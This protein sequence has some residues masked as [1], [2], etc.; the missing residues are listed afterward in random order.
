[1]RPRTRSA[2]WE[3]DTPKERA[4]PGP[5]LGQAL[6]DHWGLGR[7]FEAVDLGG[8]SSLNLL[9]GD[10]GGRY[11]VRV[12][13]PH[14]TPE[15][16]SAIHQARHVLLAGGVPCSPPVPTLQGAP[17]VSLQDR[18]V[19]VEAYVDHDAVMDSWERLRVGMSLLAQTHNLLG[20]VEVGEAGRRP[21]FANHLEPADVAVSVR[22]GT[23]RI[24]AWGRPRPSGAWLRWPRSS[25][26]WSPRSRPDW[27]RGGPANWST[28]TS[29]TTTCCSAMG[30][31]CCWPTSTSWGSGP[32]ST[33]WRSRYGAPAPTSAPSAVRPR[34]VLGCG[35]WS[36]ATTP[37]WR[38]HWLAS[39]GPRCRWRWPANPCH[40]SR[41]GGP[42]GRRGR[43][44]T[45]CRQ[46]GTRA[47][48]GAA[49]HHRAWP[50]AGR[51][52]V[53]QK[54][55]VPHAGGESAA[56][57]GRPARAALERFYRWP[58]GVG[59]TELSRL[60]RTVR[61]ARPCRRGPRVRAGGPHRTWAGR[62]SGAALQLE[63]HVL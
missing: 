63:N 2:I 38:C 60:A 5:D 45:P 16:L 39:S 8:S 17:W 25:P 51:L 15:R 1:M 27:Y 29:G 61:A 23:R 19:E 14:V 28:A 10:T 35:A 30:V 32:A 49:D 11:V 57:R 12:H 4:R 26:S 53:N 6:G 37:A 18:L 48:G 3:R 54:S 7:S 46:C 24:R 47:G 52:R 22:R 34:S 43:G 13:R 21:G 62:P 55:G 56:L 50:L 33:T 59:V 40:R 20:Q 58:A 31:R 42:L 36:P 44:T 9:V 41:V